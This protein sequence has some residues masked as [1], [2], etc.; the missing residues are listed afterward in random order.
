MPYSVYKCNKSGEYFAYGM[1]YKELW[2]ITGRPH[3]SLADLPTYS[4]DQLSAGPRAG[5]LM[6]RNGRVFEY[7]EGE[8]NWVE[9][10]PARYFQSLSAAPLDGN[11]K[12]IQGRKKAPL[13]LIPAVAQVH[14]SRAFN[15]GV[16]KYGQA[17]WREKGVNASVYAAAAQRHLALWYDGGEEL[18]DDSKVHHLGHAM[19]C[20]AIILDAQQCGKLNDDRPDAVPG[21]ADLFKNPENQ[22]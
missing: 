22:Q 13:H 2:L 6:D 15:D 1:R 11:P 8:Y 16:Q 12:D 17:N 21:L 14:L 10:I 5:T 4:S 7:V 3:G 19:A 20:L 9:H 18:A